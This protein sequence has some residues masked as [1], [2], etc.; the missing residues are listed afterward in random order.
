[1]IINAYPVTAM[2]SYVVEQIMV[3]N[4]AKIL[5]VMLGT[6]ARQPL[7]GHSILHVSNNYQMDL[8][9]LMTINAVIHRC[10]GMH[11]TMTV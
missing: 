3:Y 11:Q 9:V 5:T 8:L 4:A 1:M 2:N 7:C 6:I 10:V